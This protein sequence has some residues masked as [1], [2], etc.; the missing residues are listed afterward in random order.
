MESNETKAVKLACTTADYLD[1]DDIVPFQG[2]FKLRTEKDIK[3]LAG[4]ILDQGFSC[5][6]F[7]WVNNGKNLILDGHGRYLALE[8]LRHEGY[9]IPKLPVIL[10]EAADEAQ[11]RLKVLELNNVNGEFSKSVLLDYARELTI[12]YSNLHIAGLDFSDVQN[13]FA[14]TLDPV[15]ASGKV[16]EKDV[17]FAEEKLKEY[18]PPVDT[19]DYRDVKCPHCSAEFTVRV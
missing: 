6:F 10:V 18:H 16:S 1:L 19:A 9:T 3:V 11:A 12:D 5:P 14:P 13:K 2:R 17:A 7:I 8:H 4:Y 15:I